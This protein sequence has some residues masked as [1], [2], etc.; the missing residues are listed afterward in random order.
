MKKPSI[1]TEFFAWSFAIALV[2]NLNSSWL[3]NGTFA[4]RYWLHAIGALFTTPFFFAYWLFV[5]W[6]ASTAERAG[7]SYVS[8]MIFAIL[9]PV[10]AWVIVINYKQPQLKDPTA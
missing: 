2:V 3:I 5:R 9:L 8:F 10:I 4:E 7:R 1:K 6:V